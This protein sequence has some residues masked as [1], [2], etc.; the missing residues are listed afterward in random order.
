MHLDIASEMNARD[1]PFRIKVPA[2]PNWQFRM[3]RRTPF[4]DPHN[5]G[6]W[7]VSTTRGRLSFWLHWTGK[8]QIGDA[9]EQLAAARAQLIHDISTHITALRVA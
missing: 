6:W 9:E 4:V 3:D 2:V 7:E 8:D 5:T 1:L